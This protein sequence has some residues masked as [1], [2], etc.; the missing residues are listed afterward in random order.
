MWDDFNG[1]SLGG[2]WLEWNSAGNG[3]HGLRRSSALTVSGGRLLITARMVDGT[4][5]SGGLNH[6]HAQ[7]YGKY[8]FRVRTDVDPDK[9][10]SGVVLTWPQSNQHPRD[11]ENNIYETLPHESSPTRDPFYSFIHKPFGST[12]D[13]EYKIHRADGAQ[14]QTMTMEWTPDRITITREGPGGSGSDTWT[15]RETS[16]DLIPD[17]AHQ[18]H[19]QLDATKDS[20]SGT[21]TMEVDHAGVYRYCG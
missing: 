8:V 16:A 15:V 4:L 10:M 17:V 7:T 6:R 1:S 12:S 11:G 9:A 19:I 14:W 18:F 2:H 21:V 13:Q 3:G 5:V 20:I